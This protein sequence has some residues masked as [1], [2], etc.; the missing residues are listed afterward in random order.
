MPKNVKKSL[1]QCKEHYEEEG[2]LSQASSS[3]ED[4]MQVDTDMES[5][6]DANL[7]LILKEKFRKVSWQQL[8]GIREDIN[9]IYKR[10]EEAEVRINTAE[11]WIQ[12][13]EDVLSEL[14]KLQMQTEAKL[15]DLEGRSEYIGWK[16][17]LKKAQNQWLLLWNIC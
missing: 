8:N 16:K 14:V 17:E 9:K 10:V 13:A 12:S 11:T 7:G 4:D 3:M 2:Q 15:T 1:I 6:R 5:N